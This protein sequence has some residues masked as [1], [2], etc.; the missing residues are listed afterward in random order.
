[1]GALYRGSIPLRSPGQ[2]NIVRDFCGP[3]KPEQVEDNA[4]EAKMS[5]D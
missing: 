4:A 5:T 2:L 1:M 3:E